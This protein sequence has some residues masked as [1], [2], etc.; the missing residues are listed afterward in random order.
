MEI[1]GIH[2]HL[3]YYIFRNYIFRYRTRHITTT[4]STPLHMPGCINKLQQA[5]GN[6]AF[7]A[8]F[9]RSESVG[10]SC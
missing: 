3:Q 4:S 9:Q 2:N 7:G 8:G 10:G 1:C 5:G 6:R